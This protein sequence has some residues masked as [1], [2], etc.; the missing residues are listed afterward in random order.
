MDRVEESLWRGCGVKIWEMPSDR[1]TAH[2]G[3]APLE[4]LHE[5]VLIARE[6]RV[7]CFDKVVDKVKNED[8]RP[9][10]AVTSYHRPRA[11]D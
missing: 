11:R 5:P 3:D 9:R 10:F 2:D 6:T 1:G 4:P 8:A 7:D